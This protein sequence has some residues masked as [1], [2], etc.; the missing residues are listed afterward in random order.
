MLANGWEWWRSDSCPTETGQSKPDSTGGTGC[1][2]ETVGQEGW[3]EEVGMWPLEEQ[4]HKDEAADW[5]PYIMYAWLDSGKSTE[6]EETELLKDPND[7][8]CRSTGGKNSVIADIE[9]SPAGT[10]W[11]PGT[12]AA[13]PCLQS[14]SPWPWYPIPFPGVFICALCKHSFLV[15]CPGAFAE[16]TGIGEWMEDRQCAGSNKGLCDYTVFCILEIRVGG[17]KSAELWL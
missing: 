10:E 2:R 8:G 1:G 4:L 6:F 14:P 11:P 3:R 17:M 15:V 13:V 9:A 5:T 16:W 12:I 7:W